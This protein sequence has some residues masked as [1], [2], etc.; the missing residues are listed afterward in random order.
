MTPQG[1]HPV[2]N[3]VLGL[4]AAF[5]AGI[6]IGGSFGVSRL[7][8]FNFGMRYGILG[9][10]FVVMFVGWGMVLWTAFQDSAI[11]VPVLVFVQPLIIVYALLNWS[12]ARWGFFVWVSGYAFL[13]LGSALILVHG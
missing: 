11:W 9:A 12:E 5:V 2:R 1:S 10:G 7:D 4:T 13:F 6:V 3:L 8:G